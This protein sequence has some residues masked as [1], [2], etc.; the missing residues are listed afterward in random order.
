[1]NRRGHPQH[2]RAY[3]PLF[4]GTRG[5]DLT[6]DWLNRSID[7]LCFFIFYWGVRHFLISY[8]QQGERCCYKPSCSLQLIPWPPR[9]VAIGFGLCPEPAAELM[10]VFEVHFQE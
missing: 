3:A 7:T 10:R 2:L 8:S 5:I 9:Q 1:M 4:R 6:V